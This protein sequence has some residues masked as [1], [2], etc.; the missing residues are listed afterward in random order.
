VG[1]SA[2]LVGLSDFVYATP[3]TFILT[4]FSSLGLVAEGA[5]SFAFVQRMGI[6]KA[7]EAL[8]LSRRIPV[9]ELV[10]CGF[11]NKIF[12]TENFHGKVIEYIKDQFGD[13]LNQDSMLRIKKL[14]RAPYIDVLD[15][16]NQEEAFGGVARFEQGIPQEQFM[17][18]A[19]GKKRHKL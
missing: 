18:I 6:A 8:I 14:I 2:A 17:R 9:D 15:R 19:T 7:N 16:Q 13:H 12:P 1:L 11:V 3:S 10:A 5:A 4:P